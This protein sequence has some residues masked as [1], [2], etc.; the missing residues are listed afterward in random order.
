MDLPKLVYDDFYKFI[1]SAGILLFLIGWGTATYLFLSIK[2]IAEIHWSFW[3]IIGAYILIAGLGIT[4]ICYSIKKWK[5]NQTLLD[6]QLEAKTEQEE[7]NTELS[8]KELKSQVEEKIKDVSKTEQKRVKT[9]TDKELSRIDSKNVDL[10]RIRYLIEDK[11]IKLLEFM[12]YPRKTYRSLANSLKL[13]EHSE[14]FDK[15]ST[16]LIREVVHIC[17]KAIHANKIT[18]NEHAF[19]MDVSEKILILLEE[20]LKEA[21]NESKNSIK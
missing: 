13:L 2:N 10:M 12:N 9:K 15:Q 8:R 14:V 18:Q 5:H 19:V 17:N 1:M 3:C 4:A 11:T 21:K 16:H 6:K 7:I 20:T